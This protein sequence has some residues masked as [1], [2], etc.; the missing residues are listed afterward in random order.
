MAF[1]LSS[2][3]VTTAGHEISVDGMGACRSGIWERQPGS[4]GRQRVIAE[5]MHIRTG[6]CTLTPEGGTPLKI[7]AGDTLFFP[8]NTQGAW[9]VESTLR[10]AYV[11]FA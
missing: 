10:K 1:P 9:C 2:P 7:A 4:F 6:L 5:V 8:A 11:I 3:I